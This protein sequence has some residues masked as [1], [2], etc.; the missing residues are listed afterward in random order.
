MKNIANWADFAGM[1]VWALLCY[2]FYNLPSKTN[3][4]TLLFILCVIG[5]IVDTLF[6]ALF[7]YKWR[8]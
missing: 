8:H 2:Y 5:L 1:V 3:F 6:N 4:E 7:I